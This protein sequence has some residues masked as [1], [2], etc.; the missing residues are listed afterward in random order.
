MP[1]RI[2]WLPEDLRHNS[3]GDVLIVN[4]RDE[5]AITALREARIRIP[6]AQA[7]MVTPAELRAQIQRQITLSPGLGEVWVIEPEELN[8]ELISRASEVAA[9]RRRHAARRNARD[10]PQAQ[11]KP[12]RRPVVTDAFLATVLQVA[13]VGVFSLDPE[14][15]ILSANPAA[16]RMFRVREAEVTGQD[17]MQVLRPCDARGFQTL[18]RPAAHGPSVPFEFPDGETRVFDINVAVVQRGTSELLVLVVHD[19]TEATY[20]RELLESQAAELEAQSEE[21]ATQAAQLEELLEERDAAI[22][23]VRQLMDARSRFYAAMNHEIR[24]PINAILGFNDLILGG[25]LGPV[26]EQIRDS[27]ERSQRAARHL[28]ELVNDV[29]DLSK[30]EAGRIDVVPEHHD[31][32]RLI[33]ELMQT[34]EPT[35]AQY[36][37]RVICELNCAEPVYTDDRRVRQILLNLI[38][39]AAKFGRGN[40]ITVRCEAAGT[41]VRIDVEDHGIG[42]PAEQLDT[43]FDEFVQLRERRGPGTGLGLAISKKLAEV[44]G[45]RIDVRSEVGAGSTFSLFLPNA[46]PP[47]AAE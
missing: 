11:P 31:L 47:Q 17:I 41:N 4:A 24:T 29:L 19:I 37:S 35:V 33:R 13:Q 8:D 36:G 23:D 42:I 39:N 12:E 28:L 25:V 5:S 10:V 26:P 38:S 32:Q 40:P 20:Q 34:I 2:L 30:I 14:R 21:L 7:I 9:Q 16:E 3:D 27:L 1:K 18:L 15:R 45:G 6:H 22:A 44:L 46:G 43:I